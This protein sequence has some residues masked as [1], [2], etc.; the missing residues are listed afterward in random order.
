MHHH[1]DLVNNG[2]MFV[3]RSDGRVRI[4]HDPRH[5]SR[6]HL[7]QLADR[8]VPPP[9]HARAADR[10]AVEGMVLLTGP[11]GVGR[12]S[13]AQMLL[14]HDDDERARYRE[15]PAS[16][17]ESE[18]AALGLK[19]ILD[20]EAIQPGERLLWD[21]ASRPP[22]D[23]AELLSWLDPFRTK[24]RDRQARLVVV[25]NED[26]LSQVSNESRPLLVTL[27]RPDA[28]AVL[29]NHLR[30]DGAG[31]GVQHHPAG[32]EVR[33]SARARAGAGLTGGGRWVSGASGTHQAA[34]GDPRGAPRGG[35]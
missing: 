29:A 6:D 3:I 22:E 24:L 16:S 5:I 31:R 18:G 8:F 11:A 2:T 7:R 28:R 33:R 1:A 20:R 23:P 25:L 19:A 26:Q 32:R 15:L 21:L 10:L 12:R 4:S 14:H 35:G 17:S 30:A 13:A 9:N 34:A 27:G